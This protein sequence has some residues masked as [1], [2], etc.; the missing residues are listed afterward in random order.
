MKWLEKKVGWRKKFIDICDFS[1][2][3]FNN[4]HLMLIIKLCNEMW[5]IYGALCAFK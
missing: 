4:I 5:Y 3:K 1:T 2:Q